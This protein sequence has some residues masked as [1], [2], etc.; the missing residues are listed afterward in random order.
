VRVSLEERLSHEIVSSVA[1]GRA[2]IGVVTW[3]DEHPDVRFW[4]Y[5]EDELVI[6]APTELALG[7]DGRARFVDCLAHPIVSLASGT[8]IHTFIVGKAAALGYPIDVRIQVAGFAAVIALVRSG[9]GIAIVP[10]S[11]LRNLQ[12]DGVQTLCLQE[13]WALRRLSVCARSNEKLLSSHALALLEQLRGAYR[14][15]AAC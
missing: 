11:V 1:E 12:G 6:V 7:Q 13:P 15:G 3:N 2:D 5:H 8:A 14:D 9:A 4:P 10:R